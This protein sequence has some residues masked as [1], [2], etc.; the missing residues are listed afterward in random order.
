MR[1]RT[2]IGFV[3]QDDVSELPRWEHFNQS[4]GYQEKVREY[5]Q[6]ADVILSLRS[7][8]EVLLGDGNEF[9]MIS[10]LGREC[11][12]GIVD[13]NGVITIL[14]LGQGHAPF[15]IDEKQN[16]LA[17]GTGET[18]D[19]CNL[20]FDAVYLCIRNSKGTPVEEKENLY[21]DA[22]LESGIDASEIKVDWD[23]FLGE[24][25][26]TVNIADFKDEL[27]LDE[28][29]SKFKANESHIGTSSNKR[30]FL[31]LGD[32]LYIAKDVIDGVR[33]DRSRSPVEA[34]LDVLVQGVWIQVD[35]YAELHTDRERDV[36]EKYQWILDQLT[37]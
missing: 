13:D 26:L 3:A 17:I 28:E 8:D 1:N 14:G 31:T 7:K 27:D 22:F 18:L 12:N 33:I 16:V 24:T 10:H 15:Y 19:K 21:R 23:T 29:R 37:N 32:D 34:F 20:K 9:D 5:A 11:F 25:F 6:D 35:G 2:V 4:R 36:R 30:E